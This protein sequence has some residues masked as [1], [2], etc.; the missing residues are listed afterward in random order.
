MVRSV[1]PVI[2]MMDNNVNMLRIVS[3]NCRGYNQFKRGYLQSLLAKCDFLFLQEHWLSDGHLSS[4]S[5]VSD[6]HFATAVSDFSHE[7]LRGRHYGGCAICNYM[8]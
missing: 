2:T 5:D 1:L 3:Y 4:F 8:T 6:A 7:V